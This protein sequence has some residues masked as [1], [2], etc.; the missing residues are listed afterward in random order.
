MRYR[1]G[2]RATLAVICFILVMEGGLRSISASGA[3]A[4]TLP[5][6]LIQTV[7]ER[8][9]YEGMLALGFLENPV[10]ETEDCET[11]YGNVKDCIVRVSM[12]DAYGSGMIWEMTPDRIV[13]ATNGHVLACWQDGNSNI[14][15][16][17][18]GAVQAAVWGVSEDYDIGFLTV[19][20]SQFTYEELE[21]LR[22][23]RKDMGAYG[24]RR[25]GDGLFC[26][27]A[28][29]ADGSD[30]TEHFYPGSVGDM[31]RYLEDF[32][33]YMI[34]GYGFAKAGMSGGAVFDARGNLLGMLSGTNGDG[35]VAAVPLPVMI[36][37][38]EEL[39]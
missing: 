29:T 39:K 34:Y 36:E 13:V 11:A 3:Y 33:A 19:D 2:L 15:F 32:G 37:A 28:E 22:Y 14:D 4:D 27:G 5:P 7:T 35:M 10:L 6:H 26:V 21:R 23:V 31:W 16:P 8:D 38:W 1:K 25:P 30:V 20:N 24:E 12:G 18:R 17:V 9:L